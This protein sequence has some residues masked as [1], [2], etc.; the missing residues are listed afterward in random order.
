M[1]NLLLCSLGINCINVY[2]QDCDF[3]AAELISALESHSSKL[4]SPSSSV[5]SKAASIQ[6][7]FPKLRGELFFRCF[8]GYPLIDL[9]CSFALLLN[10]LIA[11]LGWEAMWILLQLFCTCL[12]VENWY[13][14]VLVNALVSVYQFLRCCRSVES[15]NFLRDCKFHFQVLGFTAFPWCSEW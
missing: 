7:L 12:A 13:G 3:A 5:L 6:N 11:A 4:L 14:S 8:L 1:I 10:C 2:L 9:R 15:V